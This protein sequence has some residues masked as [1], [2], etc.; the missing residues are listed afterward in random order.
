MYARTHLPRLLL[1]LLAAMI[2]LLMPGTAAGQSDST[3]AVTPAAPDTPVFGAAPAGEADLAPFRLEM[4]AG[5]TTE[6]TLVVTNGGQAPVALRSYALDIRTAI[7]G[8]Y[9]VLSEDSREA[10]GTGAAAWVSLAAEPYTLEPGEVREIPVM[11]SVPA[12]AV[13]GEYMAALATST[14]ES[15]ALKGTDSFRQ[16]SRKVNAVVIAVP[17]PVEAGFAI[18]EPAIALAEGVTTITV[19]I[20]NTGNAR[21]RPAGT[22]VIATAAGDPVAELPVAMGSVYAWHATVIQSAVAPALPEGDYVVT[23]ELTDAA[24]GATASLPA[25]PV[26][27]TPAA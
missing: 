9:E 26:T 21:V 19:P 24:T 20:Q 15:S 4:A 17:G 22:I 1:L 5:E 16:I 18:G 23:V 12:G 10:T 8:G 3:P 7:N 25:T 6:T 27:A 2:P 14:T 13:P 11:V